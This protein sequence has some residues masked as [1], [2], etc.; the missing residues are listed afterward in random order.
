MPI[1]TRASAPI[2]RFIKAVMFSD[3]PSP[4]VAVPFAPVGGYE[5]QEGD[6]LFY[7]GSDFG[8]PGF[9][10]AG[11][12]GVYVFHDNGDSTGILTRAPDWEVGAFIEK[13]TLIHVEYSED[14]NGQNTWLEINATVEIGSGDIIPMGY[15]YVRNSPD[16]LRTTA[17]FKKTLALFLTTNQALTGV[18]DGTIIDGWAI[19]GS[20]RV[21]LANQTDPTENG[22]YRFRPGPEDFVRTDDFALGLDVEYGT[23][24]AVSGGSFGGHIM[25]IAGGWTVGA[26]AAPIDYQD[27]CVDVNALQARV[28]S[29]PNP[30]EI[31]LRPGQGQTIPAGS[32]VDAVWWFDSQTKIFE[33]R[34]ITGVVGDVLTYDGPDEPSLELFDIIVIKPLKAPKKETRVL[35][36]TDVTNQ[37]YDLLFTAAPDSLHMSFDRKL[38]IEGDDYSL[39][40]VANKT[41]VTFLNDYATGGATPLILGDKICFQYTRLT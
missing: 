3:L 34:M 22:L 31:E 18:P 1:N 38:L 5:F 37:Y 14:G 36:A 15:N 33:S 28:V 25:M 35:D 12:S 7:D 19:A 27:M 9:Y 29:L 17:I 39:S 41:R 6:R 24:M 40:I 16:T 26:A 8:N 11:D 21:F 13:G 4:D 10:S 2:K 32:Y 20:H 23:L 30:N